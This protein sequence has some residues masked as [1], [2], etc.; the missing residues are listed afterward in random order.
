MKGDLIVVSL[1][2]QLK[3]MALDEIENSF[4]RNFKHNEKFH[5]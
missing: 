4:V 2:A 1:K 3:K 5:Y